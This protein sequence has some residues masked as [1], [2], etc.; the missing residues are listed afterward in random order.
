MKIEFIAESLKIDAGSIECLVWPVKQEIQIP[1]YGDNGEIVSNDTMT[2]I[3]YT[4]LKLLIKRELYAESTAFDSWLEYHYGRFCTEKFKISITR[5]G[6]TITYYNCYFHPKYVRFISEETDSVH[7]EME[8][9][10]YYWIIEN[11]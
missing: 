7:Y 11:N 10:F 9:I 4:P 8:V 5:N 2:A 1:D 3:D 6:E